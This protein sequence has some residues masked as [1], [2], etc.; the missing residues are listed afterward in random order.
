AAEVKALASG[1]PLILEQVQLDTDIK[2]LESLYRAHLSAVRSAKARLLSDEGVIATLE[3]YIEAGK[4]DLSARVDTYSE[5]KFSI[6]VGKTTYT[7]KKEAGAALMA[8]AISKAVDTE[9]TTIGSFAGFDVRVI[10]T[11]EGIKGLLSGN[12]GYSFNTYP[13]RT[14]YMITHLSAVAEGIDEKVKLWQH[15]LEEVQND[16]VEQEKLIAAPFGK[17]AELDEKRA[18]YNEVMDILN[19]KEEQS[20]DSVAEDTVQ[21][22]SRAYLGAQD[23][24]GNTLTQKQAEYFKDSKARDEN[25]NLLVLYHGT[26]NAGFTVFEPSRGKFGGSWF[27]TSRKDADSYGGNYSHKLF[28]PNETDDIRA[29][30]GGNFTLG[31]WMRFDTEADRADFLRKY[32]NAENIKTD[33]EYDALLREAQE[34]RDWDEY[35]RIEEEQADNR[36]ELK[37]L[38]RAYGIYEWEH[39]REATIGELLENPERFAVNDVLRAWDAYDSNNAARDEDY[40]KEE[41][42]EGLRAVNE[43]RIADG[44]SSFEEFTFKARIPVGEVG[45]VVN[46]ANNRTYAVYANVKNPYIINA[47]QNTLAG[48]NLYPTI[49]AGMSAGE[50]DGVIV[51]NARVGAHQ[52]TGD[53]VII[54]ESGQVKLTSN[55]TPTPHVDISYQQRTDTL[56][57]REVLQIAAEDLNTEKWTEAERGALDIFKKRLAKLEALQTERVEQGRLYKEQ[58]FGAKVDREAA[59]ATLNRMHVLDDQIKAANAEVL[60]L[61]DKNVLGD[62]LKKARKVIETEQ[63]AHDDEIFK[64]YVDR[65]KNAAQIKKYRERIKVDVN[66][67]TNWILSPNNKDITKHV[68]DVVKNSVIPFLKSIDF[69]SKQQ[70]RGGDATKADAEFTKRLAGLEAALKENIEAEGLYSGYADLPPY[71][72]ER[73][74]DFIKNV[75]TLTGQTSGEF[76]IN[77]MT[78]EEL[79]ELAGVVK[80]LKAYIT[81]M[82]SFHNNAMFA[83]VW[84]AGDNTIEA[85]SGMGNNGGEANAVSNFVFWQQMRPAY[86]FERFGEGGKAIYDGLR[87]GQAQLAFN[88]QKIVDFTEKAYTDKEVKAWEKEIKNIK[89]SAGTVKMRISD[90][91]SFYE[92]AKQPDSLRHMLGEGMRV[93]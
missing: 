59:A 5:G 14:T 85:L 45:Q 46:Y 6:K 87:R 65:T 38:Q 26:A 60:S 25:G 80:V 89:I 7:D 55:K 72:M 75:K 54:K 76:V 71:F 51:R 53:V 52:E 37:K 19:P 90:I 22:Q 40:T 48:A 70:L 69:T 3:K 21:E 24:E 83:H 93:A 31:S 20:L 73:L 49:E 62:V 68:P 32:P 30:V 66:D 47:R 44:D 2:K 23:S 64:R 8:T 82:N 67:L 50:Y 18:R 17:Q 34:A 88:T 92:L 13:E 43:E 84:E 74:N 15:N 57:N 56:T 29:S 41:L 35:D 78:S 58:Q 12:Q 42:V 1:S 36:K 79:K 27:T 28:D 81:Q 9:Y 11:H 77:K 91:M 10:K 61:E 16:I 39:S 33:A 86:A 4:K 63:R